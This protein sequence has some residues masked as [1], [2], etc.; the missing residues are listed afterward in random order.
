MEGCV[1]FVDLFML[2]C[3]YSAIINNH[4]RRATKHKS[5]LDKNVKKCRTKRGIPG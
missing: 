5:D 4:F 2:I 1:S 3:N